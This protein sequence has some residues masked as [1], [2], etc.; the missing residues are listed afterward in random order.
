MATKRRKVDAE[1]RGFNDEWTSKYFF[2]EH[3][4]KPHMLDLL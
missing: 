3:L 4:E 2:V 1:C